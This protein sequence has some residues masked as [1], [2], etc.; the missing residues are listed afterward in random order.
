MPCVELWTMKFFVWIEV[1]DKSLNFQGAVQ[2][3]WYLIFAFDICRDGDV[4]AMRQE[5]DDLKTSLKEERWYTGE[6]KKELEKIP[7]EGGTKAI[8]LSIQVCCWE[9]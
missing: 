3:N 4:L 6:L 9:I 7:S 2:N 5:I 8:P 1:S